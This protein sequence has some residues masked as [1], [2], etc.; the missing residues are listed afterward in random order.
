M[1]SSTPVSRRLTLDQSDRWGVRWS[2]AGTALS[3]FLILSAVAAANGGYDP[4]SWGLVAAPLLMVAGIALALRSQI[5]MSRPELTMLALVTGLAGLMAVSALWSGDDGASFMAAERALVYVAGLAAV[6]GLVRSDA[7]GALLAGCLAAATATVMNGLVGLIEPSTVA[8]HGIAQTGRMAAPIGYWNGLALVA[9]IGILLGL[10]LAARSA[11]SAARIAAIAPLPVLGVGLYLTFSRGGWLVLAVGLVAMIALET[12]RWQ[13][14]LVVA[15]TAPALALD[16]LVTAKSPALTHVGSALAPATTQGHRL[17]LMIAATVPVMAAAALATLWVER[18]WTPSRRVSRITQVL[19]LVAALAGVAAPVVIYGSPQAVAQNLYGQFDARPPG[20]F[21]SAH[22][23]AG[24]SLNDRLFNLSGN[25]RVELWSAAWSDWRAHMVL[26]SGSGTYE[27][28]WLAHRPGTLKVQNA[29]SLYLETLAELGPVGLLVLLAGI[30]TPLWIAVRR[31][32]SPLV[33]VAGAAYLAYL[34]HAAAD[35]DFQLPGVTLFGL[36]CGAA[37]L[38]AARPER[39][40]G[41]AAWVRWTVAGAAAFLVIVALVGLRGNLALSRSTQAASA[42]NWTAAAADARTAETWQPWS[43]APWIALGEAD[44]GGG[45]YAAA[46]A[47]FGHAARITPDDWQAWFGLARS[48]TGA[49]RRQALITALRL[50]PHEPVLIVLAR[51]SG[52]PAAS[53]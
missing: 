19:V 21:R 50:D 15:S 8:V 17:G 32:R 10:G 28:W 46:A 31:R 9:A 37:V 48:T 14:A 42:Q 49:E 27:R 47:A 35:W 39:Q 43:G 3:A 25:S 51:A 29:H 36:A 13:L 12:R 24:R 23:Q 41:V 20:G 6:F 34:V 1:Q 22:G 52:V 26:G 2:K 4:P 7:V 11:T 38:V 44:L 33:A 5:V 18:V 45:R 40:R 30:G 53:P 16:V